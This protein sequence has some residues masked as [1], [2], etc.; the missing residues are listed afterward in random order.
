[1]PDEA[2]TNITKRLNQ[3]QQGGHVDIAE[4]YR[5]V[6]SELRKIAD[7]QL[8]QEPAGNS[9]RATAVVDDAFLKLVGGPPR[10]WTNRKEF[11]CY[12]AHVVREIA[13]DHA[14]KRL[15]AKRG[16]GDR[17]VPIDSVAEPTYDPRSDE[18][19]V[20]LHEALTWLQ[21][22]HPNLA[23]VVELLHFGRWTQEQA[24][25]EVLGVSVETVRRRWRMA[26]ALL[27]EQLSEGE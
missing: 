26:K 27:Y 19:I 7:A 16:G 24:A 17:P 12:A 20:N 6:E 23:E 4:L 10:K 25:T 8:R 5:L 13:V 1:M 22:Q 3:M 14:R 9:L 18:R 21:D 2:D 15:A 11:F